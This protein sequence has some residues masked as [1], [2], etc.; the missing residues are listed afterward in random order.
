MSSQMR[1]GEYSRTGEQKRTV[2]YPVGDRKGHDTKLTQ[3]EATLAEDRTDPEPTGFSPLTSHSVH[4]LFSQDLYPKL[5]NQ[6]TQQEHRTCNSSSTH[7]PGSHAETPKQ[8]SQGP[9]K[10]CFLPMP[11]A[12]HPVPASIPA[13]ATIL[14][15]HPWRQKTQ[16]EEEVDGW[17]QEGG[18]HQGLPPHPHSHPQDVNK[19][20][21]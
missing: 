1:T 3:A 6:V 5:A 21:E 2:W 12:P 20:R 16:Q 18:S 13:Q 19:Y 17:E 9:T 4:G 10:A 15:I 8:S 7:P 14:K 11:L